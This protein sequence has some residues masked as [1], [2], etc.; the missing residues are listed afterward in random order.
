MINI[1]VWAE[2]GIEQVMAQEDNGV[3]LFPYPFATVTEMQGNCYMIV[4]KDKDDWDD[5]EQAIEDEGGMVI[6]G[7]YYTDTGEKY[8][9]FNQGQA[10]R[11]HSLQKYADK[12]ND[13]VEYDEDNIEISRRRPT[14]EESEQTQCNK[15][16]GK[17]FRN[18][19][20]FV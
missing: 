2:N 11:N 4:L 7:T 16:F 12:L 17:P 8:K 13:I 5:L 1:L 19:K 9:W 3:L 15:I 6:I 10:S 20:D 14:L 18:L